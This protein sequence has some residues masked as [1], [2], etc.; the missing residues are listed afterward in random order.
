MNLESWGQ[1]PY[2]GMIPSLYMDRILSERFFSP[3]GPGKTIPKGLTFL[4]RDLVLL[5]RSHGS[6]FA[7]TTF[8]ICLVLGSG[9]CVSL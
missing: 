8:K 7:L 3:S 4:P 2:P 5:L 1:I 6:F 9:L